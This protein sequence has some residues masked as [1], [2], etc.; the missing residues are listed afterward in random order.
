MGDRPDRPVRRQSRFLAASVAAEQ[1]REHDRQRGTRRLRRLTAGL[2]IA[3]LLAGAG[4][5]V[6]LVQRGHARD[7]ERTAESQAL[8]LQ[9]R[10]ELFTNDSAAAR[11][12]LDAWGLAHPPEAL[13]SLLSA[14]QVTTL[15]PLGTETRGYVVAVSPDGRRVA[16][17][18]NDGRIQLWDAATLTRI[19]GDLH[20]PG[21]GLM[22]L[23][24]SPDGRYLASGATVEDGVVVW[25][26]GTGALRYRLHAAGAVA[27]LPD[28]TLV[29]LRAENKKVLFQAGIWDPHDG[30]LLGSV[31]TLANLAIS[32]AISR[33]GRYLAAAGTRRGD[34][35][36]LADRHRIAELP[37]GTLS[38]GFGPDD[39]LIALLP[40]GKSIGHWAV[41]S[42]RRLADLGDA[43]YPIVS[44]RSAVAPD[45]TVF[46]Q[47][48]KI[49]QI[50]ELTLDGGAACR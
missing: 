9:A 28:S 8:A 36:R 3:L 17:G 10:T 14:Q 20:S 33:D 25:D 38:V 37:G 5:V 24:F 45:G 34:I 22:S 21:G 15:G 19:G 32:L 7:N 18:F 49:G 11:H 30:R 6:A 46:A 40:G 4:G 42:G 23:A 26:L 47:G 13:S 2:A 29:A 27:W 43:E 16:T 1:A 12:A 44:T 50:L 35:V 31:P 48:S 39:S 41:P